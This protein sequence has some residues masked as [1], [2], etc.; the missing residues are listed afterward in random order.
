MDWAAFEAWANRPAQENAAL[1]D[2]AT[3]LPKWLSN[4]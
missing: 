1:T 4:R 3:N 2:F